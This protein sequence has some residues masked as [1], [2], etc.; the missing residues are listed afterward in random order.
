MAVGRKFPL[1]GLGGSVNDNLV[2][3]EIQHLM[4]VMVESALLDFTKM[5]AARGDESKEKKTRLDYNTSRFW[6]F[7]D[8]DDYVLGFPRIC[9]YF[10]IDVDVARSAIKKRYSVEF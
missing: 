1:D 5:A 4:S 8:Y 7:E 2:P 3:Y 6:V 9:E 10:D